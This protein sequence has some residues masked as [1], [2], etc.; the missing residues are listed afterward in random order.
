MSSAAPALK[1]ETPPPAPSNE[2]GSVGEY[3]VSARRYRPKSFSELIGQ[4]ALVQTLSNGIE[5]GRL[6]HAF[7]FTGIRGVGKTTTARILARSLNCEGPD[8]KGAETINPCG[9]CEHCKAIDE[10]RHLDV[11]EMDAAS[12]T[13][14]DDVREVIESARYKAVSARYK[15]YIIDEVHMLSKSAFNALLKTLEEPPAHVKFI[16]ATTEIQKVPQTVLSRCMRFDLKRID[17]AKLIELFTHVCTSESVEFEPQSLALVARAADGS[18]RDGLSILD[19][20]ITTSSGKIS[21]ESIQDMLGLMDKGQLITLFKSLVD[22]N[23]K[24]ALDDFAKMY[25]N[26]AEPLSVL[27][28]LLDLTHWLTIIKVSPD[29]IEDPTLSSEERAHGKDLSAEL[30]IPVLTRLWQILLKGVEETQFA[31]STLQAARMI[32]VRLSYVSDMPSPEDIAKFLQQN[33]DPSPQA[34]TPLPET[35]KKSP[36]I[37]VEPVKAPEPEPKKAVDIPQTFEDMVELFHTHDE[38]LLHSAILHDMRLIDYKP[39]E[40]TVNLGPQA[41]K[42]LVL[43]MRKCLKEWTDQ[44]W[45]VTLSEDEGQDSLMDQQRQYEAA[46]LKATSEAPLVKA[47]LEAFPGAKIDT[48]TDKKGS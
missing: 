40:I 47:A 30:S 2:N 29:L 3:R 37:A 23:A 38:P 16:F 18:A 48:I 24:Q 25:E 11:I 33:P 26:G 13:G 28:D 42:D 36:E 9:V 41:P 19:Q 20:A 7:I 10:D 44:E 17:P 21:L 12:K 32:L 46:R 15:I 43:R 27:R 5:S 34:P 22:G 6:P 14:V 8:G 31:P 1:L 4:E 39:L 35:E 45:V